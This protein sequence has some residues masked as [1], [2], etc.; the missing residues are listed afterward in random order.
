MHATK[1][2]IMTKMPEL[3]TGRL[4]LRPFSMEDAPEVTKLCGEWAIA[5]TTANIPHPYDQ[6]MAEAWIA[7]HKDAWEAGE[8]VTFAITESD[9]GRLLGAI[10]IQVNKTNLL[11]EIGYW[12]GKPYWNRGYAT[13][14]AKAV[15]SF[16]FEHLGL[17]RIQARHMTKNPASGRVLEKAGMKPEGVLR[18]SIYRWGSFED[19]A[20]FAVLRA[21]FQVSEE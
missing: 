19:A 17:N 1:I 9:E 3:F 15:I 11:G 5:E 6:S 16:G 10:G 18:Q 2:H 7:S 12:I 8:A 20:M 21:E 13:Q 4:K 14:A